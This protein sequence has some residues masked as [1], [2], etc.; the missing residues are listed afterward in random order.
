MHAACMIVVGIL[1]YV[2]SGHWWPAYCSH[3]DY[4]I[5][6]LSYITAINLE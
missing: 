4:P 3:N 2:K 5:W 1:E 6:C